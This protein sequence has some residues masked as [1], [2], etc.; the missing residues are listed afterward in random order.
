M[1]TNLLD[2]SLS[3]CLLL[4]H[5]LL[6]LRNRCRPDKSVDDRRVSSINYHL[7]G[8]PNLFVRTHFEASKYYS[9]Y[10][11]T[12]LQHRK[13]A[14]FSKEPRECILSLLQRKFAFEVM[15]PVLFR[16]LRT[17][18]STC[19]PVGEGQTQT[20]M[21][22]VRIPPHTPKNATYQVRW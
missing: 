15:M 13:A 6:I 20:L 8:K 9:T 4:E 2:S 14:N 3:A 1:R 16:S 5:T 18:I 10:H 17:L 19:R 12:E 11:G 7:P 22:L 21:L